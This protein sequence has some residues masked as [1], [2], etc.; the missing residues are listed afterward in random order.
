MYYYSYI[1]EPKTLN[2]QY[3]V[4]ILSSNKKDETALSTTLG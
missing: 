1:H 3:I 2:R 4:V